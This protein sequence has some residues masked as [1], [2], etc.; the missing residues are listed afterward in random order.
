MTTPSIRSHRWRDTIGQT[1]SLALGV[2]G[3]R[4]HSSTPE[5]E[6]LHHQGSLKKVHSMEAEPQYIAPDSQAL[7]P[8]R[9]QVAPAA[10][11][12]PQQHQ[13][14]STPQLHPP[15][16]RRTKIIDRR[17]QTALYPPS[18]G[19]KGKVGTR[20]RGAERSEFSRTP[21]NRE[22][23]TECSSP[24]NTTRERS[25]SLTRWGKKP[26]HRRAVR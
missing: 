8:Q 6:R 7:G 19:Y 25:D 16:L 3:S 15:R 24:G 22:E 11:L 13:G 2:L 4:D 5:P 26:H 20:R 10:P 18:L 23:T 12:T 14:P 21:S 9:C 17:P 1:T